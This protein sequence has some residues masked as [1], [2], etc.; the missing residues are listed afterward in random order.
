VAR[1]PAAPMKGENGSVDLSVNDMEALLASAAGVPVRIGDS[2]VMAHSQLEHALQVAAVLRERFP[3][4]EELQVAGLVHDIGQLLPGARDET[5]AEDGAAAV[6][7]ALGERV[8]GLVGLHVVAKRYLVAS[9]ATYGGSL[10][11]DSVVSLARQGGPLSVA[12]RADFDRLPY[13]A[14]ALALRRADE[15]GKV[16]GLEVAG[17]G[18]WMPMVRKVHA[19]VA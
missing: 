8:A 4:D 6:R 1:R 3:A 15:S 14:D 5:H 13:A 7:V 18:E 12:E 11:A 17:L 9:E 10:A 2:D 16:E 19:H